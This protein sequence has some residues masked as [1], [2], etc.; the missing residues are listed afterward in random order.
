[1]SFFGNSDQA[2]QA[3][4]A[5]N[6]IKGFEM[7]VEFGMD[8]AI[9]DANAPFLAKF[10]YQLA[11]LKGKQCDMLKLVGDKD[12]SDQR[13]LWTSLREGVP[14]S[15]D[16]ACVDKN[17]AVVWLKATYIPVLDEANK[18]V[19]IIALAVC[20]TDPKMKSLEDASKLTAVGR[21]QAMIEFNL[22]GTII[23]AMRTF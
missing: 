16:Q 13:Q 20:I 19:R 5:I 3:L 2:K 10:G 1:M 21:V 12:S 18:P 4:A 8:G 6:A 15:L 7:V 23:S 9:A 11:D 17:G 14:Q 22:D